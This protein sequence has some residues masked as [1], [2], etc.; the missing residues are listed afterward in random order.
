MA[1]AVG[2]VAARPVEATDVR[3]P[4]EVA[5]FAR[6]AVFAIVLAAIYWYVSYE[7]A[8]TVLLF[9]FGVGSAGAALVLG[10]A[11]AGRG[12]GRSG[13]GE[14]TADRTRP[15]GPFGDESA[16]IP[17]PTF[18]PIVFGTG[19]AIAAL[20]LAFGPWMLLAAIMPLVLGATSWLSSANAEWRGYS[21]DDR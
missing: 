9:L 5:F 2:D 8:G 13:D 16:P 1:A 21:A 3:I 14:R 6:S 18:A 4:E 20:S 12:G 19:L 10:R 11:A 7:W 15:D 17:N